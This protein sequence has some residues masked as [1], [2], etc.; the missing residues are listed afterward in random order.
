M[1]ERRR[2]TLR[3]HLENMEEF[4]QRNRDDIYRAK[5]YKL[6]QR[7]DNL[8][9]SKVRFRKSVIRDDELQQIQRQLEI[10]RDYELVKLKLFEQYELLKTH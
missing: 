8:R 7:I 1:K 4:E 10:E 9:T 6:L 2:K 5:K 3:T